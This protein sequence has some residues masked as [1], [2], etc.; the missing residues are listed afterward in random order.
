[1]TPAGERFVRLAK[2]ERWKIGALF[3]ASALF[4]GMAEAVRVFAEGYWRFLF[5]PPFIAF[6]F[7][8][9]WATRR[10][11]RLWP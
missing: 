2:V 7:C 9:T 4:F 1:M 10:L 8:F 11:L 3:V 5:F 6:G